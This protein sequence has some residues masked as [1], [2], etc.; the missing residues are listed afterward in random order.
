MDTFV[1]RLTS[2]AASGRSF[3]TGSRSLVN[4]GGGRSMHVTALKDFALGC[5]VKVEGSDTDDLNPM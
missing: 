5:D 2:R 1:R 4:T 3:R